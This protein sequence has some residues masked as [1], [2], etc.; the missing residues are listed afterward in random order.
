MFTGPLSKQ[1]IE[2]SDAATMGWYGMMTRT[3]IFITWKEQAA[4]HATHNGTGMALKTPSGVPFI[5]TAAHILHAV[6][7]HGAGFIGWNAIKI[8]QQMEFC[9][10]DCHP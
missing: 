6:R 2:V 10:A 7:E 3:V 4:H 8:G 1:D 5:L 9:R